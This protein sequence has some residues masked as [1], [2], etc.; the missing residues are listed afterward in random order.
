MSAQQVNTTSQPIASTTRRRAWGD[1][2]AFWLFVGPLF[3]G[4]I[5]FVYLPIIW[6]FWLSFYFAR[7]TITP[8]TFIGWENYTSLLNDSAFLGALGTVT[9]FAIFIVPTTFLLSLGLALLV[10]RTRFS[11]GFFR[12][13]FFIPTACSYVVA[14][15]IWRMSLFNGLP[16]GFA[17]IVIGW[18]G[19]D[20]IAWIGTANPPWYWL[21]LVTCRLWLQLGFYMIIFLAGLQEIPRE[22][23]EAANVDGAKQGWTTFRYITFPLLR[24]TSISILLLNI[25]AAFQAFAE[26]YNILGG[27]GASS[28]NI[29]LARPPLVYLYSIAFGQ[30][31]YGRGSAGAFILAAIIIIV[32]IVQGRLFGLGRS[33][34]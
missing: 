34:A 27:T 21:V 22:L 19:A 11:Q 14:S 17:N 30:Q 29:T 8:Q 28:G 15:L 32:T 10:N 33:E 5:V 24:N 13:V 4:L 16:Y 25:I 31:D 7:N 3:L 6:G 20:P 2:L 26:F 18:F 23:Y 9:V 12:S 1:P